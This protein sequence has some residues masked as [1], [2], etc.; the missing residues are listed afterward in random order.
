MHVPARQQVQHTEFGFNAWLLQG[1]IEGRIESVPPGPR[2]PASTLNVVVYR[3]VSSCFNFLH[4][5]V[6]SDRQGPRLQ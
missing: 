4:V 6:P 2:S 1:D 5:A 3:L